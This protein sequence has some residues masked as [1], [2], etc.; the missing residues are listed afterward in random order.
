MSELPSGTLTFLFTDVE[1]STARWEHH[2]Q[3]MKVALE[4][5]DSILRRAIEENGG[6]VF[7]LEGD[8]FR[9]AFSTAPAALLAAL[10]AQRGF[11]AQP[12]QWPE[13]TGPLRVRMALHTGAVE[14]KNGDYVGPSLNRM[15]R[16]LSTA[17]GGQTV[18]SQATEQLVRDSL[19]TGANLIDLGEHR[20]RDLIRPERIFQ[21]VVPGLPSD[22]PPLKTLDSRPNNLPLQ[23]TPFIGRVKEMAGLREMMERDDLRLLT[24]TGVGGTG[25][26]RL[27]A[28]VAAD[29]LDGYPDGV[30]FVDLA[31]LTDNRQV[32]PAVAGVLGVKENAGGPLVEAL[33]DSVGQKQ[34]LL[35]LDNFERVVAAA[36]QV[37]Q[38]LVACSG[39]KVLATS[40]VPL[41]VSQ[42]Q[43]YPVSP[44]ALPDPAH[45]PSLEQ[46]TQ[47]E[48]VRLFI[49]RAVAIRPD[50]EVN[51][52]N[53]PAVAEICARLDGLPLA[54]E[55][56]A[57]RIRLFPPRAL[58]SRLS[59]RLKLLTT[60]GKD[61]PAR[62]QT[63]RGT[64]EWSYDLLDE[65][66]RQLFHRT[67]V[68]QGGRTF[69]AFE[70]VCNYD[71]QLKV[72]LLEGIEAL[73]S[74]SLMQ[75][76][77]GVD[78]EPRFL[79]LETIQEYGREKLAES[80]EEAE[81][82]R[83]HLAYY[84]TLAEEAGPHLTGEGQYEWLVRLEEEYDNIRAGLRW[85][86]EEGERRDAEDGLKLAAAMGDFWGILGRYREGREQLEGAL[87]AVP[88]EQTGD[89]RSKEVAR[90]GGRALYALGA[91]THNQGDLAA[92]R[93][94]MEKGLEVARYAGDLRCVADC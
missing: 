7:R 36:P 80:G 16:L 56:A 75:Q 32:M 39:L 54:I 74:Q 10:H 55:L 21:L 31:P 17:H 24:L 44:L 61:L 57:A 63:L 19:P 8:A 26:T 3:A 9:A 82:R 93:A 78:G 51:N 18:L 92:A 43:E 12:E 85:A 29:L 1:G 91:I 27:A 41:R 23:P 58:L 53:A 14:L 64:I 25:K 35:V 4:R 2:T 42:E 66:E 49:D 94:Y 40:R 45:L 6:Y 79:M 87:A 83:Q 30:W 11:A 28:Q 67:A 65:G 69:E 62:Q 76:R 50:F 86:R 70:A 89:A 47:Y 71:G 88:E 5:H 52:D 34:M 37:S 81:L 90:A 59:S 68:F 22:F 20:L 48:A 60:G 15:A 38:L 73:V 13:E 46:L 33:I 84:L 77:E 72:D